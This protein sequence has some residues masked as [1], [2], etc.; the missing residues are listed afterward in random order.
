[1]KNN[2]RNSLGA[3][4][5]SMITAC[6]HSLYHAE[7]DVL[8]SDEKPHK[9]VLYWSKTNPLIGSAKAGPIVLMT[10]CSTRRLNFDETELGI[11]F[12][13]MPDQDRM[14]GQNAKISDGIICGE[15]NTKSSIVDLRSGPL[16][17][18]IHCEAVT[19]EF[20]ISDGL[21]SPVYIKARKAPYRYDVQEN[22]SWSL[23]GETPEAPKPPECR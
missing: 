4:A 1:M 6:S 19:D 16:M 22:N 7:L 3:F 17:L 20:S 12:R 14:P 9:S 21:F 11:V 2:Y 10:A 8:S 5:L 18:T 15:V 23:I 13:G